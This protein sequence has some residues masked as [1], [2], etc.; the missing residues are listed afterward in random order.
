MFKRSILTISLVT[1]SFSTFGC[2]SGPQKMYKGSELDR[3]QVAIIREIKQLR[4]AEY[5]RY[6]MRFSTD[7]DGK[8]IGLGKNEAAV[9]PGNH[10][11]K[12]SIFCSIADYTEPVFDLKAEPGRTYEPKMDLQKS[13]FWIEDVETGAEVGTPICRALVRLLGE[14][15]QKTYRQLISLSNKYQLGKSGTI[16]AIYKDY[17][18]AEIAELTV[19]LE[20]YQAKVFFEKYAFWIS[21]TDDRTTIAGVAAAL[22]SDDQ[23][24]QSKLDEANR[25]GTKY[26]I[27]K[28]FFTKAD[29][30]GL[31][32]DDIKKESVS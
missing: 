22:G 4:A 15:H 20:S 24:I 16:G 21:H 11:V 27:P 13:I 25:K 30:P 3:S 12:I 17:D 1:M 29:V 6:L 31:F 10:V 2:Q 19:A 9:L 8:V 5:L 23:Q 18:Q 7:I 26:I 32:D 14:F 28:E